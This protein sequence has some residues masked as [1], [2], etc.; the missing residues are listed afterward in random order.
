M[1]E[2]ALARIRAEAIAQREEMR[3]SSDDARAKLKAAIKRTEAQTSRVVDAIVDTGHNDSLVARLRVLEAEGNRLKAE[4]AAL[5]EAAAPEP[6]EIDDDVEADDPSGRDR[7]RKALERSES[8][9]RAAFARVVR[10]MIER[11]TVIRHESG[12]VEYRSAAN[13][14]A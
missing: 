10:S 1:N 12:A 2:E 14:L 5:D 11:I 13:S 6:A 8:R 9:R 3:G 4:L 7:N